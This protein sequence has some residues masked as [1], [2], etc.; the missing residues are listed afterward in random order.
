MPLTE[1]Y[2]YAHYIPGSTTPFY[3][4]KGAGNR[5]WIQGGRSKLWRNIVGKHGCEVQ[6]LYDNLNESMAFFLETELIR[7]HGRRITSEGSLVNITLG[8]EGMAGYK[9]TDDTKKKIGAAFRGTKLSEAHKKKLRI[10]ARGRI[11][12]ESHK[13]ALRVVRLG[14]TQSEITKKR[15]GD[16]HRGMKRSDQARENLSRGQGVLPA[17]LV[18][19]TGECVAVTN[20]T[21]FCQTNK[22]AP[23]LLRGVINGTATSH[24][25]W[26]LYRENKCPRVL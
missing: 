1:Y 8:G 23:R 13:A 15:I 12:T 20:R 18:S 19:P 14:T 10:A 3:I 21:K 6:I 11:L 17:K 25:G 5:A 9:H 7:Q 16:A 24:N 2:V 22:L 4:G 26:T